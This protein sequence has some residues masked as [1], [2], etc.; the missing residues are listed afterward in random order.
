[1]LR[2]L[3]KKVNDY[4]NC[5]GGLNLQEEELRALCKNCMGTFPIAC[6]TRDDLEGRGYDTSKFTDN[7]LARLASKMG[8]SYVENDFWLCL[9]SFAD[10]Y[11][12]P[13]KDKNTEITEGE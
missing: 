3:V 5:K 13:R 11:N 2:E 10:L 4:L 9:D 1:M 7:Q 6:L 8:D 12:I